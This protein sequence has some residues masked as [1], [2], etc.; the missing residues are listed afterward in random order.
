MGRF[1]W[2]PGHSKQGSDK[3]HGLPQASTGS[4]KEHSQSLSGG[5]EGTYSSTRTRSRTNTLASSHSF[6]ARSLS[7]SSNEHGSRPGSPQSTVD[8]EYPGT[9]RR[10]STA[11]ALLSKGTRMLKRQGSKLN[12]LPS[13][14]EDKVIN[15]GTGGTDVDHGDGSPTRPLERQA[16]ISSKRKC[17]TSL[18]TIPD[19]T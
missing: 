1:P 10:E 18:R 9:E 3:P 13:Q 7:D 2:T 11:K 4:T 14:F 5:T 17:D 6:Y 8:R 12:L 16:T 19:S 15:S